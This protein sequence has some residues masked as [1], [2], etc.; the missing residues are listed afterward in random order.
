MQAKELEVLPHGW[1]ARDS[2]SVEYKELEVLPQGWH[3]QT[4]ECRHLL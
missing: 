4:I 1:Q 3:A 2:Y